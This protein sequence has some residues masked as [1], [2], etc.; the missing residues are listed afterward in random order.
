MSVFVCRLWTGAKIGSK[1]AIRHHLFANFCVKAPQFQDG[2][3]EATVWSA[4]G[5]LAALRVP[6]RLQVSS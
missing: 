2:G 5:S 1:Y 3:A 6:T 4:Q